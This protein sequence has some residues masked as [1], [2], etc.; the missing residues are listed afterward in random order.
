MLITAHNWYVLF[1]FR[2]DNIA[3][4]LEL[5]ALPF[6]V[7]YPDKA[8]DF[9]R[10]LLEYLKTLQWAHILGAEQN[11][12][13]G[14]DANRY[15]VHLDSSGFPVAPWPHL[16]TKFTRSDLKPL[17]RIYITEH[18][19]EW[20][21]FSPAIDHDGVLGLA[22]Q[23]RDWQAPFEHI[24]TNQSDFI[25]A[26]YLPPNIL[27]KDPWSIKFE[28]IDRFFKHIAER[29]VSHGIE[30]TFRFKNVLS[31]RRKG[32]LIPTQYKDLGTE[33]DADNETFLPL[34]PTRQRRPMARMP[35]RGNGILEMVP[36][37][38]TMLNAP[39]IAL[40]GPTLA[41]D[42]TIEQ[43]SALNDFSSN[44]PEDSLATPRPSQLNVP[45]SATRGGHTGLYTPDDTPELISPS[46]TEY[47]KATAIAP[48]GPQG[49]ILRSSHNV[50]RI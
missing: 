19:H 2:H 22:C 36:E 43:P 13:I 24:A 31:S 5:P 14:A 39:V 23:D 35:V 49:H 27:I 15:L 4:I 11:G 44:A 50:F 37:G 34:A 12:A 33:L 21:Q 18:Y 30:N 8:K 17:Y 3:Q 1:I 6:N 45:T 16:W 32:S 10:S 28:A 47:D 38:T 7:M 20:F 25:Y 48:A 29:E 42:N 46:S 9:K 41:L 40:A 26:E